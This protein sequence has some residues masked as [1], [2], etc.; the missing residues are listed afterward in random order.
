MAVNESRSLNGS[1]DTGAAEGR[2]RMVRPDTEVLDKGGDA[3]IRANR[4]GLHPFFNYGYTTTE[5]QSK[6]NPGKV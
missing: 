5:A 1:L 4:T 3:A 2:Y 6:V